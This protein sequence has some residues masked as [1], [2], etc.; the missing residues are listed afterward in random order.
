MK[1]K[2]PSM[3][4]I[5]FKIKIYCV[6]LFFKFKINIF[7]AEHQTSFSFLERALASKTFDAFF[8]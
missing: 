3:C 8:L 7:I 6:Y 5:A 2:I 1:K 4:F